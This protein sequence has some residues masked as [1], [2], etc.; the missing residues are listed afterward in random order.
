MYKKSMIKECAY[1]KNRR[2]IN[3]L[4]LCLPHLQH[5]LGKE[6]YQLQIDKLLQRMIIE[7]IAVSIMKFTEDTAAQR[8]IDNRHA[9][10]LTD[11][12]QLASFCISQQIPCCIVL[13]V[14]SRDASLPSGAFCVEAVADIDGE[15][16][17]RVYRRAKGIP[18]DIVET[19]RLLIREITP[20]DVPSLYELYADASIT[21]YMDDLYPEMEQE[22]SY[23]RDYISNI[24]GFY[25]YGMWLITLKDTGM[26]IGRAGLEYKEGYEGLEL[27]FMLGVKYQQQGYAYEACSAILEYG[28]EWL[29][30]N[31]F[32]A[33]V[34]KD[35]LPSRRLCERLGFSLNE[36]A[37]QPETDY[38]E[39]QMH[40]DLKI[41]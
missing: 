26:V 19:S 37:A 22:I 30:Q 12:A 3:Q 25:G 6:A 31:S 36:S 2:K 41:F 8:C 34:H 9:V 23:T 39:Y 5:E 18:W 7:N 21:A 24:Y 10:I 27:G 20:Q 1:M 40:L 17:E 15:Y 14:G 28:R 29:G 35:N 32:R 4:I 11:D 38:I 16:L 33:I 13:D